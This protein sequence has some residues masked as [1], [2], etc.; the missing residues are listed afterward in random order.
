MFKDLIETVRNLK[1]Y[2]GFKIYNVIIKES[3]KT[4]TPK[5]YN[6]KLYDKNPEYNEKHCQRV[7]V[8]YYE[9]NERKHKESVC[10]K[11]IS[12][13]F[14]QYDNLKINIISI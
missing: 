12:E 4:I 2:K 14:E 11:N 13:L 5:D 1:V 9:N 6:K 8:R 7:L 3:K 10:N